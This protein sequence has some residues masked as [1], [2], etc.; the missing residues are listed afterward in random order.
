MRIVTLIENT[1][2]R[3]ELQYEHGLSLYIEACGKKLLFDAGESGAFA[4]NAEKL[5]IDLS[6]VD[7]AVLSHAH[8][9]H[10]GGFLRFLQCNDTAPIWARPEVKGSYHNAQGY[11]ISLDPEL[12]YSKRLCLSE[13]E[14]PS[15]EGLTLYSGNRMESVAPLDSAGL[16]VCVKG[17]LEPDTFL[18]EQYLLIE[19]EGKR[20]LIS[21]CSHKGIL[22]IVNHFRPD[23]LIGGFHY[24]KVDP[25]NPML[26]EA[27][28]KLLAYPTV[29]YTG[30][31]TGLAQYEKMKKIM[32]DRLHSLST[33]TELSL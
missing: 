31:C 10:C 11:C 21:G 14:E 5:G 22:N 16:S 17:V 2:A 12:R 3:E 27:A 7:I 8:S 6:Q 33:G 23:V 4:D 15:G 24:M 25:E 30:H 26:E 32:A 9:D 1:T 13:D 20:V 28:K 19:E 29:Y 18:H